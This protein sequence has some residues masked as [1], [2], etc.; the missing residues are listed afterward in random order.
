MLRLVSTST[1]VEFD[2]SK[3]GFGSRSLYAVN[4]L[5]VPDL[6]RVLVDIICFEVG[7]RIYATDRAKLQNV[8]PNESLLSRS[9]P[10]EELEAGKAHKRLR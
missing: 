3:V 6:T 7:C 9:S 8:Q 1:N 4:F 5:N 2:W 10:V